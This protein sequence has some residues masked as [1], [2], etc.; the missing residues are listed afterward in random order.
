MPTRWLISRKEGFEMR[1][2]IARS[3]GGLASIEQRFIGDHRGA[4]IATA[5]SWF[6]AAVDVERGVLQFRDRHE[7]RSA[8]QRFV[9]YVPPRSIVRMPV[10]DATVSTTGWAGIGHLPRWPHVPLAVPFEGSLP[11]DLASLHNVLETADDAC[12]A[13]ADRG[14]PAR[15]VDSRNALLDSA[16]RPLPVGRVTRRQGWDP[17]V[18]SR[19]F[20]DAYGLSPRSYCQRL[21][22]H[23]AMMMLL[24]GVSIAS[25]AFDVG[26]GDLS[27][28][29]RQ[30][31]HVT[32]HAPGRYRSS[33]G[34]RASPP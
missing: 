7:T 12:L 21:R 34:D 33:V 5:H 9:L 1:R 13:G 28:F 2:R 6:A 32:G 11:P 15:I 27:Q 26:F 4:V 14:C 10:L 8:P 18:F 20:K 19:A 31:R 25:A 17:S 30:F 23:D 22:V 29:Y 16:Y 24:T 3:P